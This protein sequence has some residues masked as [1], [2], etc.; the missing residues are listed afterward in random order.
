[1]KIIVLGGAGDMGGRAVEDLAQSED[2]ELLTIADRNLEQG[3]VLA[4]RLK[5]KKARVDFKPIDANDHEGL[6]EAIRGY[7]LAA[8]A[9]GPFYIFEAKLVAAAIEAG[10]NYTSIC[11]DWLAAEQVLNQF[12]APARKKGVKVITGLGT[13]PGISNVGIRFLAQRMDKVHRAEVYVYMPLNA[14]GGPAVIGH[15]LFI[16]SGKIPS[17]RDGKR[18]MLKACSEERVVEFPRFGSQKVW[19]MGHS[20]PVTVPHF[21]PGIR[22]VNF[23]MGFG[24][25]SNLLVWPAK[26]GLFNS[27]GRRRVLQ[28]VFERIEHSGSSKEPEWGAVRIEVW[29]EKD[30]KAAH[31]TGFGVGQMRNATGLSLSVGSLMLGRNEVLAEE[32]GVY[33]PEACFEPGKFLSQMKERGITAYFDLEM[34]RPVV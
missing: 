10:V 15:T 32:G 25:G 12:D 30:G 5:G 33:G 14:G 6:V 27:P 11:D 21:I 23:F 1:M 2:V 17:W 24:A 18:V 20:E 8:S 16:M 34:K 7:D 3:R 13:S 29:G 31:E 19:N 26:M 9:L 22:E 28:G 4:D